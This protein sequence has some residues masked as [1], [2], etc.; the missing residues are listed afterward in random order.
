[1]FLILQVINHKLRYTFFDMQSTPPSFKPPQRNFTDWLKRL[2][3]MGFVFFL[4]KGLLW[5]IIPYLVA[6]GWLN[7]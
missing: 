1:L 3:W 2:G 7:K 5:L 6:K 4:I